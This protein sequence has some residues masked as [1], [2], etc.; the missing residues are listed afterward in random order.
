V[1]NGF[2]KYQCLFHSPTLVGLT[3]TFTTTISGSVNG[4]TNLYMVLGA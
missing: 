3:S 4:T 2:S 1:A